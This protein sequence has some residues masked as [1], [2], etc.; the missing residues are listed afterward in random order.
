MSKE[1]LLSMP[2]MQAQ[3]KG[4]G[5]TPFDCA[6]AWMIRDSASTS[7]RIGACFLLCQATLQH[8][9]DGSE[10]RQVQ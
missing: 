8:E 10:D 9:A 2:N 6:S 1:K 3:K 4:M 7:V 5:E